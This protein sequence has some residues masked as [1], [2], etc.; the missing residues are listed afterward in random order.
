MAIE[1]TRRTFTVRNM[2][3]AGCL[4]ALTACSALGDGPRSRRAGES[5]TK[6]AESAASGAPE[7]SS[8][9]AEQ[10][11]VPVAQAAM[12]GFPIDRR[13]VR[14]INTFNGNPDDPHGRH[15]LWAQS[16]TKA[17]QWLERELNRAWRNGYTRI[18]LN[19]PAGRDR[20]FDPKTGKVVYMSASHWLPMS[21]TRRNKL[22]AFCRSW[23]AE[24][25]GA[26]LGLYSGFDLD[27]DPTDIN[28]LGHTIPDF[29]DEADREAMYGLI[30]PWI[31]ECG[32]SEVW[33][34]VSSK[35]D[36][37]DEAVRFS[38]WLSQMGIKAG[39]EAMPRVLPSYNGKLDQSYLKA[40]P[41]M[42]LVP[43]FRL[44]DGNQ[45]WEVDPNTTEAFYAIRPGDDA[46]DLEI[47][48]AFQRG[49]IPWVYSA[50]L[51]DRVLK[52]WNQANGNGIIFP[53]QPVTGGGAPA[54]A[55]PNDEELTKNPRSRRH[56]G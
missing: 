41:W 14:M 31:E 43:Y 45:Q 38:Q 10:F 29:S 54:N 36:R 22:A 47:L 9:L 51:D 21:E 17:I 30:Q 50:S 11:D 44:H 18:V 2:A 15:R 42:A 53:A 19:L 33:W 13:P 27:P 55:Q 37:R 52:L 32:F 7:V 40:M 39:G 46:T 6:A 25:P 24:H 20:S 34:D 3:L 5:D 4:A 12:T 48:S 35:P 28:Y 23:L 8:V 56:S 16:D 49:F 1:A 26:T